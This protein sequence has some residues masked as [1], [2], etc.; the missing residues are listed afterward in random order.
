MSKS[1][2]ISQAIAW[3][4][5]EF[6]VVSELIASNTRIPGGTPGGMDGAAVSF[7]VGLGLLRRKYG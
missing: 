1:Q 3:Y 6:F 2:A 5:A 7:A 4:L